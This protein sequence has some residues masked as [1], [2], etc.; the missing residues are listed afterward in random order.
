MSG[1]ANPT[2]EPGLGLRLRH[3]A[4]HNPLF[5]FGLA[6]LIVVIGA[7]TA[8]PLIAPWDPIAINFADKLQGPNSRHWFGTDQL[9]RDIYSQVLYGGRLSLTVGFVAVLL[10]VGLGLPVGLLAGYFS[11]RTDTVLM[12]LSDIFLAFP[13]L[14]LPLAIT[15]ALGPGLWN[16]MLA[17]AVSWFPWYARIMRSS[18]MAVR[19]ELYIQA[20]RAM[21]VSHLRI[22]LRHALPNAFTPT[23]VQST[24]DFGYTI[25]AAAALSFIGMG[26]R[27]PAIEWGLMV[28]NARSLFLEY[29]WTAAFPGAAIFITVL[30][31]NLLGDGLRDALDP[32]MR[33]RA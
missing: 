32:T 19:S 23:L 31:I 10:S 22:M 30:A 12:R 27:P 5:V 15:A 14:F 7:A 8:A 4:R 20:A 18:V 16:L 24:M 21:G 3:S 11:G 6:I 26:A 9:G 29:W 33:Q 2:T 28:S 13:P 17:L 1:A 25:L